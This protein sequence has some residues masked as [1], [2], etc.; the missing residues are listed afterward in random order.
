[1]LPKFVYQLLPYFYIGLGIFCMIIIESRLIFFS[2]ALLIA[3]GVLVLWMRHKNAVS[4]VEYVDDLESLKNEDTEIILDEST[5][6]P[7]YDRRFDSER[8][9]PLIDHNDGMIAFDRRVNKSDK[10]D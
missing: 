7:G 9:F 8:S 5:N 2:S 1:M 4:P 10:K 6:P 3:A